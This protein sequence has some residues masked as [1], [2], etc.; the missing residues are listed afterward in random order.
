MQPDV[1]KKGAGITVRDSNEATEATDSIDLEIFQRLQDAPTKET[2]DKLLAAI[3]SAVV[4]Y[5]LGNYGPEHTN[6]VLQ[7][8][9]DELSSYEVLEQ[10]PE[11]PPEYLQ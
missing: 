9:Q 4:A 7:E 5:L 10:F 6:N 3:L 2:R 1:G 11:L 8:W